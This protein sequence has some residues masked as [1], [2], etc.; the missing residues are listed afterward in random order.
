[1]I[2]LQKDKH[3]LTLP[4]L[5]KTIR[6]ALTAVAAFIG[7]CAIAVAQ[8]I[9]VEKP[10][11][12]APLFRRDTVSICFAGDLMMHTGQIENARRKNG[13]YDFSPC[14]RLIKDRLQGAD[15][16]IGNMEFT[17]G[18][19]PYTG[20]PRFSAPDQYL[21]AIADCGF[22]IL[23]GANNH[24]FDSGSA[25]AARTLKMCM[26]HDPEILYCGIAMDPEDQKSNHPLTIRTRGMTISLVNFTYGTNLGADLHW[27]K[28]NY[29]SDRKGIAEALEK[30]S[31]SDITVALPHWGNEY[32]HIHSES[33]EETAEWLVEN[34]AD[35]IIGSHP[36][37]IQDCRKV[38]GAYVAYSI[39]NFLSNMSAPGTQ[40]GLVVTV[41]LTRDENGDTRMLP[42]EFIWTW[43]SRPGGF[44]DTYTV[45]PV[46]D[47]VGK[48]EEWHGCWDYDKMMTTFEKIKKILNE[49]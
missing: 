33:Q 20:Y 8:E 18:G 47:Y 14:F 16:C 23:L 39:G 15:I 46:E 7:C 43:C 48:R 49:P 5:L 17:L 36:H 10:A 35:L 40:L 4:D 42:P 19:S 6:H 27:P 30:A 3:N 21:D 34:G 1:M 32:E 44:S 37:V 31:G 24:I 28:V 11:K 9:M 26:N 12:A 13:E 29:M 41:R 2:Y 38:K 25:G 22:D 45:I